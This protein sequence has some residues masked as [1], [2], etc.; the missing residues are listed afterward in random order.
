MALFNVH[1]VEDYGKPYY[2]VQW[3]TD[4][5]REKYGRFDTVLEADGM[6]LILEHIYQ[7]GLD[8]GETLMHRKI[9]K[10]ISGL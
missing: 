3:V 9:Q 8:Q 2:N 6:A 10:A 5:G 7:L 1:H 4:R